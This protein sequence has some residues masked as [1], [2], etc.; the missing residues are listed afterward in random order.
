L[1]ITHRG[2]QPLQNREGALIFDAI[3][4]RQK[5]VYHTGGYLKNGEI[6]W[7]LAKLPKDMEILAGDEVNPYALFTN[8]H[9]GTIAI[10]FRITTVRVVCQNTL[11]LALEGNDIKTFFKHAHDGDYSALQ[12]QA[13][14]FFSDA[15]AGIDDLQQTFAA[16]A[17]F[18]F[19][20]GRIKEFARLL[21][22]EPRMPLGVRRD[23]P[24][25]K[26]FLSM[27]R[28]AEQARQAVLYLVTHGKGADLKGVKGSLWGG[29]NA[30]IEYI[31]HYHGKDHSTIAGLFG[32]RAAM[33]RKAFDLAVGYL[34]SLKAA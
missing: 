10:D 32:S 34:C 33:K 15:M 21:F 26:A 30:V 5:D 7:L 29:L 1:G 9:H 22:P 16:M 14:Q 8:S 19:P 23:S 13:E 24:R 12:G 25:Y 27:Q 11:A 17:G 31:D 4:G 20:E 18:A 28:K 6:V 3:F 2:F